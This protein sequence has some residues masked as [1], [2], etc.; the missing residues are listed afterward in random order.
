[1]KLK[2]EVGSEFMGEKETEERIEEDAAL[3]ET[4]EARLNSLNRDINIIE[5]LI[6]E[7]ERAKDTI[8]SYRNLK[9]GETM[10]VP[11]G[12]G[13]YI[14][15]STKNMPKTL[16]NIGSSIVK[17]GTIEEGIESLEK[18][19]NELIERE[20]SLLETA[21]SLRREYTIVENRIRKALAKKK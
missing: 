2:L 8:T 21:E 18:R 17:E 9:E 19:T 1:M 16:I 6:Q 7:F 4:Y 3:L 11:I 14:Y 5:M 20:K 15:G 10:L 12:G 13:Y